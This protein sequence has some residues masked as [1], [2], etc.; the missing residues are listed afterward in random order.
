MQ[1]DPVEIVTSIYGAWN[2]GEWAFE[3]FHPDVEWEL[4]MGS[5]DEARSSRGRDALMAYWRRFWAAWRPG[6]QWEIEVLQP[7]GE[8]QVLACGQL[9][10]C[11]RSSGLN[12]TIPV[13]H[14]W[15]V[16]EGV[17]VRLLVCDDRASALRRSN[18]P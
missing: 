7:R 4:G 12:T 8:D 16:S 1:G 6:A 9:F 18:R 5:F 15:T 2:A 13:F 11:G 10:V 17:I 14:V 3:Q